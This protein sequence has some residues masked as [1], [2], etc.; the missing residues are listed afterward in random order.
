M[1]IADTSV[2]VAAIRD[3]DLAKKILSRY[4]KQGI[5]ISIITEMELNIGA[6]NAAKK[7][8]VKKVIANH[9]VLQLNKAIGNLAL[10]LIKT[11]NNNKQVLYLGDALIAAFCLYYDYKLIT[12]NTKDFKNIK[13]IQFAL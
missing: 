7:T 6:T 12:F 11:Y 5:Y 3:N 10:R 4:A 9:E 1:V 13:G 2:V 8:V